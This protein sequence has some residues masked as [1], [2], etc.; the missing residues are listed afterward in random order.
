MRK[1][2]VCLENTLEELKESDMWKAERKL[3]A[4]GK[5]SENE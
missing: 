4:S 1:K 2:M 5:F 3:S